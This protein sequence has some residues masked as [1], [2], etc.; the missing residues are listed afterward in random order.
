MD[1]FADVYTEG[2]FTRQGRLLFGEI[3]PAVGVTLKIRAKPEID[4]SR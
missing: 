2:Q 1:L 4:E 3:L